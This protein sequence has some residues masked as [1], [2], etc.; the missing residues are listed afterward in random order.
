MAAFLPGNAALLRHGQRRAKDQ[1][2]F[3]PDLQQSISGFREHLVSDR[4]LPREF[5]GPKH[6][7]CG[8]EE[9][10]RFC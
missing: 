9:N 5:A 3:P 4:T 6:T 1:V 7:L 10:L 8:K 2:A